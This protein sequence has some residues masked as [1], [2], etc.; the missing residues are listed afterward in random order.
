MSNICKLTLLA[1]TL[2]LVNF[3]SSAQDDVSIYEKM[4]KEYP[5]VNLVQL[6][7]II[8]INIS[9]KRDKL[10]ITKKSKDKTLYLNKVSLFDYKRSVYSSNFSELTDF[11]ANSYLFNNNKYK[12]VR[13]KNYKVISSFDG[14][15]FYDDSKEYSFTFPGI[16]NGSIIEINTV[17]NILNPKMINKIIFGNYFP[18]DKVQVIFDVDNRVNI[19]FIKKNFD[20]F[21]VDFTEEKG[22]NRTKYIWKAENIKRI[23]DEPRQPNILYFVPHI[24]PIIR[25]YQTKH[26]QQAVLNS[27]EDLY[28]WYYSFIK[29]IDKDIDIKE[30]H[31]IALEITDSC[32]TEF[33][34][35]E[36]IFT[37]V[38]K[39]INY[40]AFEYDMG[41]LIPRKPD[42]VLRK[43]YGD[44]KDY[45]SI[46]YELLKQ[47]GIKSHLTWIGSRILP[48]KFTEISSPVADNHMILTYI[49]DGKYYFLDGTGEYHYLGLPTY[50][51]QG[52]QALIAIDSTNFE[53][54]TVPVITPEES[55]RED[56]V[57]FWIEGNK[58]SGKGLYRFTGYNKILFQYHYIG[59]KDKKLDDAI[60]AKLELGNNR[61]KLLSYQLSG[62]E[63]YDK[64]LE[65]PYT[66]E[67][68]E[69]IK[70]YDDELYINMNLNKEFLWNKLKKDRET[71][72]SFKFLSIVSHIYKLKIPEGYKVDFLPD[73][74]SMKNEYFHMQ[75]DYKIKDGYV[76]YRH[77]YRGNVLM[78]TPDLFPFWNELMDNLDS[79]YK[80][81]IVLKKNN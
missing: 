36:K 46:T 21:N 25:N 76:I 17:H 4:K 71:P 1:F 66:F 81:A 56:S 79:A 37:W 16:T 54:K 73:N 38:Q 50:S 68:D 10:V 7:Q 52:K 45:T 14:S 59:L 74:V 43:R 2:L 75:I 61:F 22:K 6:S 67:V 27:I 49:A 47:A 39:N 42:E 58:I 28:H 3:L 64:Q 78:I 34:K 53:I 13:V 44:C 5:D 29:D 72:L 65:I 8:E 77:S 60:E 9:I 69:F 23:K 48:Y 35:V 41:G 12:K 55:I 32:E 33:E 11:E 30:L 26:G 24:I 80:K 51:I 63:S 40:V 31:K 15:I 18:I 70:S 20:D 19:D 62:L 57:E